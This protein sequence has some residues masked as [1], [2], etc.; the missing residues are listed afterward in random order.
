[1]NSRECPHGHKL[2]KCHTCELIARIAELEAAILEYRAFR[3]KPDQRGW[4][5]PYG[6]EEKKL[7][8]VL[9]EQGE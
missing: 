8:A 4:C 3:W 2:G 9:Q 5:L 6:G 1:M 7:F